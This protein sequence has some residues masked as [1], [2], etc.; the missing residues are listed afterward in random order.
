[1]K[2]CRSFISNLSCGWTFL[3]VFWLSGC[4]WYNL[5]GSGMKIFFFEQIINTGSACLQRS[6]V[7]PGPP[8]PYHEYL[9]VSWLIDKG[10]PNA[11]IL[12]ESYTKS[13]DIDFS[14]RWQT[15][16]VLVVL[17]W[18]KCTLPPWN[19][20]KIK[21]KMF[22]TAEILSSEIIWNTFAPLDKR[23]ITNPMNLWGWWR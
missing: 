18:C 19:K 6:C 10:C 16:L 14:H 9:C 20:S 23:E 21:D 13:T 1:M 15:T 22:P 17:V 5:L 11:L 8:S 12:N 7:P 4:E 2:G 3:K